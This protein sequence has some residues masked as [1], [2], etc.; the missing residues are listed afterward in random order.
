VGD[1]TFDPVQLAPL[2]VAGVLYGARARTLARRG[3]PVPRWRRVSFGLGL[4]L[5]FVALASPLHAL[6][7]ERLFSAHMLQHV[8][9]G[10]LAALAIVAGLTGPLLRPVLAVRAIA[11]LR[12]LAHP[13]VALPL[14]AASLLLWHVPPLYE[15]A[16][17]YDALHA[18]EH[19]LFFGCGALMWAPVVEVLPGPAWFGTGAKIG[20]VVAVRLIETALGNVFLW[21]GS[22]VYDTYADAE[23]TW[24]L[25]ASADQGIAGGIMMIEGSL[26]TIGALAWLLLRHAAESERRQQLL[27]RGLDPRAVGRAVRYG[28]AQ[29]LE[30]RR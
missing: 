7:E 26:V 2:A 15:A 17:H 22:P 10:D 14:W 1:W 11:R 24:G 5:A 8:L 19:V 12:V 20:Y 4:A 16:L 9:L 30:T 23:R 27:E 13:L 6:G 29:E 21:A 3:S 25:S 18:L 28:R